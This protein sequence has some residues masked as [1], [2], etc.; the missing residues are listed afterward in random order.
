MPE[1]HFAEV[2]LHGDPI[3]ERGM[4]PFLFMQPEHTKFL[5]ASISGLSFTEIS[6]KA[7]LLPGRE[8]ARP[9]SAVA[10][11]LFLLES[12]LKMLER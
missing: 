7:E 3:W 11:A 2:S 5:L 4:K 12:N 9:D 8:T 1:R 10:Q 6:Q